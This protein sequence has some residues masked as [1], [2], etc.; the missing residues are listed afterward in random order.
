MDQFYA[1]YARDPGTVLDVGVSGE[2]WTADEG[3]SE[4]LF[5][6]TFRPQEAL[7]T[8]LGIDDLSGVS[9]RHPGKRFVEYDGRDFPFPDRAFKWVYS[10]AVIEHVGDRAAQAH[11]LR[12]M[13]RVGEHVFFTTPNKFFPVETHTGVVFLHW[14]SELFFA[15]CRVRHPWCKPENLNL[16]GEG[17]LRA[18]LQGAGVADAELVRNR[19]LAV[20]MT[21]SVQ[22]AGR[23]ADAS[24]CAPVPE[25]FAQARA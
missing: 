20:P 7:Y 22:C 25:R 19:F 9:R 10:N 8:G 17:D 1:A 24:A 5:L 21:Y 15:W 3:I 23:R 18:L 13:L 2:T 16:I 11:F 6:E 12:E 4:N 14:S